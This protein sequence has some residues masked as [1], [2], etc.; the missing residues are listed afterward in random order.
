MKRKRDKEIAKAQAINTRY[1]TE[2]KAETPG[3]R[4][5]GSGG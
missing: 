2:A 3:D 1:A 5:R 4:R